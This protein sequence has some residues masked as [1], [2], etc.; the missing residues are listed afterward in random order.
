MAL[1]AFDGTGDRWTPKVRW[2]PKDLRTLDKDAKEKLLNTITHNA[3]T[4]KKRYLTNVVFFYKEYV[5]A[6]GHAEYF[7]GVGTGALFE[8]QT[9]K[10][11]DFIFGGTFGIGAQ[12][13]VKKAFGRLQK[14]FKV[15]DYDIDIVGY[16]R[17]A[18]IGRMFADKVFKDYGKLVDKN[19]IQLSEPPKIRFIGLFDT[20][21]SFGNP[22]NDNELFFQ[23]VLPKT[24]QHTVHAMSL[25]IKRKGFGLDRVYG[26]NVLEVWFRGGHGDV[27]GNSTLAAEKPE[28]KQPNRERTNITLNFMLRKARAAFAMEPGVIKLNMREPDY[29]E[30]LDAPIRVNK[31][32]LDFPDK[33]PSRQVR[34]HDV[35]HHSMFGADGKLR[36]LFDGEGNRASVD[37][38]FNG[39]VER[40][41]LVIEE[42][43]NESEWSELR[44]VQLTP[45]LVGKF[46]NTQ[47]IYD[48]LNRA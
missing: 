21:A 14:N 9:G 41:Q 6:G 26:E 47:S 1:Y 39:S 35:F 36:P 22:L 4:E 48:V 17:G 40:S 12:G 43:E 15:G 27:G 10:T 25:D 46:P 18:A 32:K 8:T 30:S 34:T 7:P 44:L 29:S 28:D 45:S 37:H 2:K 3:K 24:V 13:L 33:D 5:K 23:N 16:S 38:V 20:V 19:N 31:T 11:L 42:P